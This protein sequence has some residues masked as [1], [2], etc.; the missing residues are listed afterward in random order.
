MEW[1]G[2]H[3]FR[4]KTFI[5]EAGTERW[6]ERFRKRDARRV[7][8]MMDDAAH[9]IVEEKQRSGEVESMVPATAGAA[10]RLDRRCRHAALETI[11][12]WYRFE[13][14]PAFPTRRRPLPFEDLDAAEYTRLREKQIQ[15]RVDHA[16]LSSTQRAK[17][18]Y[19]E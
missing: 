3:D 6:S 11:R 18:L 13:F 14:R 4:F 16:D 12:P 7:L 17:L 1:H 10:E 19:F 15:D 9:R 2:H 8:E 5:G